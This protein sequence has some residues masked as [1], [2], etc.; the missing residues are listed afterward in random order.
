MVWLEY[1]VLACLVPE[2]SAAGLRSLVAQLKDKALLSVERWQGKRVQV[3]ITQPGQE[4]V[5]SVFPALSEFAEWQGEWLAIQFLSA[6]TQDANFR[7]LRLH[8]LQHRAVAVSRGF[9]LL[10]GK[11]SS[12]TA[13]ICR[14]LY[15]ENLLISSLGKVWQGDIL[16]VI[17]K[18][19]ALS[20]VF[21]NYSGI[22][23]EIQGMLRKK[24]PFL[25]L[26]DRQKESIS[27]VYARFFTAL[28]N[29]PGLT[30]FYYPGCPQPRLLLGE[31]QELLAAK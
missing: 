6:P 16:S 19:H 17:N 14:E 12:E 30:A 31:I 5:N 18:Q 1:P 3:R 10:P 27:T 29:D 26:N 23:R 8:L 13:T 2:I 21:Q 7:Y 28:L 20:D 11:L 24:Q 15:R 25:E 4:A 9:Y 22:S